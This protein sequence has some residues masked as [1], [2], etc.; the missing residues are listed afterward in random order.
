M[1]K[2]TTVVLYLIAVIVLMGAGALIGAVCVWFLAP[3]EAPVHGIQEVRHALCVFNSGSI[4]GTIQLTEV[5][6]NPDNELTIKTNITGIPEGLH[7]FHIHEWGVPADGD[8]KKCGGHF[9]PKG[10]KHG[11]P[12]DSERHVGDLGNIKVTSTT[13][14]VEI[15]DHEASLWGSDSVVGRSFVIHENEDDLGSK[16]DQESKKT[17]NAGRRLACCTIYLV[18]A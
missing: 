15:V 9:N 1:G 18:G 2:C 8:C 12:S 5:G 3:R 4:Y 14:E 16:D 10:L 13:T 17:G 11:S 6:A 7:G